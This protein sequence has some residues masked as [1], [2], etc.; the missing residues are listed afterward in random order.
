MRKGINTA[1]SVNVI[2]TGSINW[3]FVSDRNIGPEKSYLSIMPVRPSLSRILLRDRS[4]KPL[5]L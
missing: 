4:K 5:S 3:T 1:S 2:I